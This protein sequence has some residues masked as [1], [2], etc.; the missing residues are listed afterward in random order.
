MKSGRFGGE[1]EILIF[2]ALSF[3]PCQSVSCESLLTSD[4]YLNLSGSVLSEST[5]IIFEG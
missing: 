3:F 5:K 4:G 1:T 2:I